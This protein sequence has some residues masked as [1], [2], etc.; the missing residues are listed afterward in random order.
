MDTVQFAMEAPKNSTE[1]FDATKESGKEAVTAENMD[2]V[3]ASKEFAMGVTITSRETYN[4]TAETYKERVQPSCA[5]EGSYNEAAVSE[6]NEIYSPTT[7][8]GEEVNDVAPYMRGN[9]SIL[10]W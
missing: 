1:T 7:K 2:T 4:T 5:G 3:P 6:M 10:N 8:I 9:D